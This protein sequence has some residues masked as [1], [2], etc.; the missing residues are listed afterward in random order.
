MC[1]TSDIRDAPTS[2]YVES[3]ADAVRATIAGT[4]LGASPDI[5]MG[6]PERHGSILLRPHQLVAAVRIK[7]LID[8]N[9]GA[10]LADEVGLG[11]TYVALAVAH[12]AQRLVVVAPA[13]LQSM[14]YAALERV[15]RTATFV[16]FERLSRG[17][18]SVA[19][20]VAADPDFFIVD[21]AHH[22]RTPSTRR[23]AAIAQLCA[24]APALLMSATPLQNRRRDVAAQLAL[25]LGAATSTMSDAEL[26]RYVVRRTRGD[27]RASDLAPPLVATPQWIDLAVSRDAAVD[28]PGCQ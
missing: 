22:V 11:K 3:T 4:M 21:E 24:R 27:V 14:W 20:S 17:G 10:L 7:Q 28:R 9:G 26:T 19:R 1:M 25:F 2:T 18:E 23:Y 6:I 5:A 8:D 12:T 15:G 13:A 16:S